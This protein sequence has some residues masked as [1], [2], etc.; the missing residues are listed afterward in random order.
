[1]GLERVGHDCDFHFLTYNAM[2]VPVTQQNDLIFLYIS[3]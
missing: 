1:M 2:L 3:K